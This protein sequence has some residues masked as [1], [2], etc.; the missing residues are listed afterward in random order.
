MSLETV[1]EDIREDARAEAEAIVEAAEDRAD[2][3]VAAAE[4]EADDIIEEAERAVERRIERERDQRVSSA[5]LEAK[6]A[7]LETRR[8]LLESIREAVESRI[9]SLEGDRRESLTRQLLE[10]AAAEFETAEVYGR[11]GD[12][13][14]IESL[15]AD[16]DGFEYAGAVDCLGGV[17][18]E[19]E[20][21]RLR[22]NNT[23]DSILDD[24]WEAELKTI[25]ERLFDR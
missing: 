2:D 12:A 7:R 17:V 11:E 24:V 9:A 10:D 15:L 3:I 21:S 18:L 13:A 25:S 20:A 23:F 1:V 14:L 22:V 4:A 19:S 5:N 6:Q 16:R 8:D